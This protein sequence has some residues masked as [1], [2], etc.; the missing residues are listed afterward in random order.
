MAE[1]SFKSLFFFQFRFK[2]IQTLEFHINSNIAPKFMKPS[3]LGFQFHVLP[4]KNIKLNSSIESI[5]INL[6]SWIKLIYLIKHAY[7]NFFLWARQAPVHIVPIEMQIMSLVYFI[8]MCWLFT[9]CMV[10]YDDV[11]GCMLVSF[12]RYPCCRCIT[13]MRLD[14]LCLVDSHRYKSSG[15]SHSHVGPLFYTH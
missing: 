10:F 6:N 3:L 8:C 5:K 13:L 11:I 7:S 9:T 4:M 14:V 1:G 12:H 2:S 15:R